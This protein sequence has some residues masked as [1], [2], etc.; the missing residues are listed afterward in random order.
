MG[1]YRKALRYG[2]KKQ[3]EASQGSLARTAD[4]LRILS[5]VLAAGFVVLPFFAVKHS[6]P[7]ALCAWTATR[8][9]CSRA[10]QIFMQ[11]QCMAT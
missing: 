7:A 10:E 4:R 1:I 6:L 11:S 5:S 8:I 9:L 3:A 2:L